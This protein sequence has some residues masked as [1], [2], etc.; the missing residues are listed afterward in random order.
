MAI[1]FFSR[2]YMFVTESPDVRASSHT[3]L[4]S[5]RWVDSGWTSD[6][7]SIGRPNQAYPTV[8]YRHTTY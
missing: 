3:N 4:E 7:L 2:R 1:H 6:I 8:K 5:T